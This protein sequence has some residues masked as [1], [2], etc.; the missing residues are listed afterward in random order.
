MDWI[1]DSW[2]SMT[3]LTPISLAVFVVYCYIVFRKA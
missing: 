3:G 2:R 1:L